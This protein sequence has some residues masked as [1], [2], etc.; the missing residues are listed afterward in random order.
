MIELVF[1]QTMF[2]I[3]ICKSRSTREAVKDKTFWREGGMGV[4]GGSILKSAHSRADCKA[5][6]MRCI[7]VLSNPKRTC[8][9]LKS[10]ALTASIVELIIFCI[11]KQRSL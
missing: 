5:A 8:T 11:C 7:R 10:F 6:C 1:Q 9:R 2:E 3:R 4:S